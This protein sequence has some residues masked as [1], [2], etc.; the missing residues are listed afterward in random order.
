MVDSLGKEIIAPSYD[1]LHPMI[2][3]YAAFRKGKLYGY[4]NAEGN[5]AIEPQFEEAAA[6]IDPDRKEF[7]E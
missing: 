6:L 1:D 4:L 7:E 2:N 5:I 3:G